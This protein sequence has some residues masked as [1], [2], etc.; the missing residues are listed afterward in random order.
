[1]TEQVTLR[2]RIDQ[3]RERRGMTLEDLERACGVT[4]RS[5]CRGIRTRSSL[6]A[7]AYGLGVAAEALVAGTDAEE[8][9]RY[10]VS[11]N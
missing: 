8:L 2:Q 4:R 10:G 9:W 1:M 7:L 5:I 11:G 6:A 3:L